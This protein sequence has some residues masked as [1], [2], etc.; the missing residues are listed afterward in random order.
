MAAL[1]P[2]VTIHHAGEHSV[3]G[4]LRLIAVATADVALEDALAA[5]CREIAAITDV[6]V[7][8]AYV[9]EPDAA[10]D[11]LVLRGN[12][13]FPAGAVGAVTL[14]FG[15]GLTGLCAECL[16]P[17]SV[18]VGPD[19]SHFKSVP[20]LG[21]EQFPSYLGVPLIASGR[22]LGVLV[23]QQ[24]APVAFTTGEVTLATAL[25]APMTLAVQRRLGEAA[26]ARS[27]RLE[28]TTAAPGAAVARAAIVPTLAALGDRG[29]LDVAG[30]L[31]R[32]PADLS[33]AMRRLRKH[34]DAEARA[35]IDA[36]ELLLLDGRLHERIAAAAPTV[37]GLATVARD[38]ARAPF[39]L[40]AAGRAAPTIAR[41]AEI[42]DL[43]VL[44]AIGPD[45]LALL[46]PGGIWIGDRVSGLLALLACARA[47]GAVVVAGAV[48]PEAAAIA[49]ADELAVVAEVRG[50]HAW[51]RPGDRCTVDAPADGAASI[52]V[53]PPVAAAEDVRRRRDTER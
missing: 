3:D 33:R 36:I 27:V 4:V 25:A 42:E 10:G 39:R 16:R 49:R 20:G 6:D 8:S 14:G 19:D 50:L 32:L 13:G 15:E 41:A 24:R 44:L 7:V 1:P 11:R 23:L 22:A 40:A 26:L 31:A 46:P 51:V 18:A 52:G 34:G 38:Y 9:R 28:G 35:A 21:E 43:L 47:A 2:T 12:H 5:M 17:V 29:T 48:S 30:A 37:D 53:N 45:D